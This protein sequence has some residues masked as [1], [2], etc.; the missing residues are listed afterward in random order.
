M[1]KKKKKKKK[2]KE[3]GLFESNEDDR[4]AKKKLK[5]N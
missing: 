5:K 2:R 4:V 1:K 3:I